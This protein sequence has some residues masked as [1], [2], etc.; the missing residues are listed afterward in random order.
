M[1]RK[2]VVWSLITCWIKTW[3]A[4]DG[5]GLFNDGGF[6]NL[7]WFFFYVNYVVDGYCDRIVD[8]LEILWFLYFLILILLKLSGE[9]KMNWRDCL[10]IIYL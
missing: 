10:R 6:S 7:L 5:I 1:L 3:N 2:S 4:V 8:I 9:R